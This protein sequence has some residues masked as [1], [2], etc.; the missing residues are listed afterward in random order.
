MKPL[1]RALYAAW[2]GFA[3][4]LGQVQTFLLLSII[5]FF[6]IG[7]LAPMFRLLSGDPLDRRLRDRDSVWVPKDRT[8][9]SLE[10]ARRLF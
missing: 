4:V 5:Y 9:P 3:H 10:E 7:L 6:V 2:M 8:N 1:F